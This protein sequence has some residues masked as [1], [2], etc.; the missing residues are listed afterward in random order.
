MGTEGALLNTGSATLDAVIWIV[1]IIVIG[2]F[3]REQAHRLIRV[4]TQGVRRLSRVLAAYCVSAVARVQ[5]WT[6]AALVARARARRLART[7]M[8]LQ[9]LVGALRAELDQFP[10]LQQRVQEQLSVLEEDYRSSGAVPPQIPGWPRL[11]EHMGPELATA[12]PSVRRALED[13]RDGL[14]Q[15]RVDLLDAYRRA[16][17]RRYLLLHRTMP[18]WRRTRRA[19]DSLSERVDRLR[20]RTDRILNGMQ[21]YQ[22]LGRAQEVRTGA[23]A[24][25][26]VWR[27]LLSFAGL[28]AAAMGFALLATLLADPLTL[29]LGN[30]PL[31]AGWPGQGSVTTGLVILAMALLGLVLLESCHMTTL[32]PGIAAMPEWARRWLFWLAFLALL[33]LA[34]GAAFLQMRYGGVP[35]AVLDTPWAGMTAQVLAVLLVFL[36]PLA[37]AFTGVALAGVVLNTTPVVGLIAA[38][39]LHLMILF[40]RLLASLAAFAGAVLVQVYD[41]VIFLPLW[42]EDTARKGQWSSTNGLASLRR[43]LPGPGSS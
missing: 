15:Q 5:A 14:E 24:G 20:A 8:D 11:L 29:L 27:F 7:E 30:A 18:Y 16:A 12:D 6:R 41:L 25:G 1:L 36:L 32:L 31:A 22:A 26:V 10:A 43:R 2:Y 23:L 35:P 37:L 9:Y 17:R 38:G 28:A 42:I 33:L 34:G 21:S 39:V 19:L 40:L 13:L 4:V 3:A